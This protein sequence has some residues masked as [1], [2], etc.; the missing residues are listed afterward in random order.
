MRIDPQKEVN[1]LLAKIQILEQENEMLSGIAE[2][3]FLLYRA[4]EEI[5]ESNDIKQILT[6]TLES[7]SILLNIPFSS[8]FCLQ[9][10]S[11]SCLYSYALFTSTDS[12]NIELSIPDSYLAQLHT[13]QTVEIPKNQFVLSYPN[14]NF[15]ALNLLVISLN[16]EV[17]PNEYF[18]FSSDLEEQDLSIR[19]TLLEKLIRFTSTK[20]ERVFFQHE[21]SQLNLE[22]EHKVT[23]RTQE[24]YKQNQEYL[25][26]NEE[27]MMINEN[28]KFA[29]ERAEESDRLK[30]AFLQNMSHEIRTPMNAIMGFSSLL[31]QNYNNKEKLESYAKIINQRS[32]D[33]LEIISDILDISKIESGQ[34][35]VNLEDCSLDTVL[36]DLDT[37]FTEYKNRFN[38]QQIE[39]RT[40]CALETHKLKIRTD[41]VKLKQILINLIGNAF[42]FTEV[43]RI[44]CSCEIH[45][46][47]IRF[48]VSDTGVGIPT[49]SH[50]VIFER[51]SQLQNSRMQNIAGTGL[52]LTIAKGLVSLLGG[53][54]WLESV[55][56]RGTTFHFTIGLH[57]SEPSTHTSLETKTYH[58]TH[59]SKQTILI[60]EDDLYNLEYLSEILSREGFS[61][62]QAT[63]SFDAIRLATT[64]D[65]ALVLM[66]I[67]LPDLN[68][69]ETTQ[70]IKQIKPE[71]RIIA[72]TAYANS[73]DKQK[74]LDSG[75]IAHL[76]KPTRSEDLL[77]IVYKFLE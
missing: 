48:S 53:T 74:A 61:I 43:G 25:A 2:D 51:F 17:M 6:N 15:Q 9:H 36:R 12:T 70:K 64:T 68:G 3:N 23:L 52:G 71:I 60:V 19:I 49:E 50:D 59:D 16:S 66:D 42:K 75:C 24:L 4:F 31:V 47:S 77:T 11:F 44:V 33:L 5:R 35:F 37:F 63:T 55:L 69:Y 46:N 10:Q 21:L 67:R 14:S 30:T 38:K 57:L 27:Y 26:L 41:E 73:T 54:I 28:L 72:Q 22:L 56:G 13:H 29:K 1:E 45:N 40:E 34:L 20:L 65:V 76:S 8:V 39:F 58:K 62:L 32:S 7:I 18:V